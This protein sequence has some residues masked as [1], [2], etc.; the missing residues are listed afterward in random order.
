MWRLGNMISR[1][2]DGHASGCVRGYQ[3]WFFGRNTSRCWVLLRPHVHLN[4]ESAP[5][6]HSFKRMRRHTANIAPEI[7]CFPSIYDDSS[8]FFFL[9]L[10]GRHRTPPVY[11][12]THLLWAIWRSFGCVSANQRRGGTAALMSSIIGELLEETL[13]SRSGVSDNA[14]DYLHPHSYPAQIPDISPTGAQT[15]DTHSPE[16]LGLCWTFS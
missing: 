5:S 12:F 9:K 16:R 7:R 2:D 3:P 1:S 8:H 10:A 4:S 13:I 6:R 15:N 11:A 14:C